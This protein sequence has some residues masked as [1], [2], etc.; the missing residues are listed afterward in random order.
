[1][2]MA[3]GQFVFDVPTVPYQQ[4]QRHTAWRHVSQARVG[5]RPVYQYLGPGEDTL[6]LNGVQL[7]EFT[8]GRPSLDLLRIMAE[9]GKA[10]PL[11]EGT[12][13][14][15]GLWAITGVEETASAFLRDARRNASSS[16]SSSNASTTTASTCSAI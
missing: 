12:G 1:M 13:Y 16:A 11:I 5:E 8:G 6:T 7:P 2:M 14:I 3:L 4:L 10:W 15:Y 9:Q